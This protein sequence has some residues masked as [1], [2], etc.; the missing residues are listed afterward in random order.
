MSFTNP[1]AKSGP[2]KEQ[3]S[4][5]HA[6]KVDSTRENVKK[7]L[8]NALEKSKDN[9]IPNLV[10]T[11]EQIA[12]EIEQEVYEQNDNSAK[13]RGYRD[14]IRKLEM[15]IKGMRNNYIREILKKGELSVHDFCNL[16]EKNLNDENFFKKFQK[17]GGEG[18]APPSTQSLQNK[19]NNF[20]GKI[21]S[22][23]K[24]AKPHIMPKNIIPSIRPVIPKP[25]FNPPIQENNNEKKIENDNNIITQPLKEETEI[26]NEIKEVA[27]EKVEED[28]SNKKNKNIIKN[29]PPKLEKNEKTKLN[30][31]DNVKISNIDENEQNN[32]NIEIGGINIG[33]SEDNNLVSI[34]NQNEEVNTN[35][36]IDINNNIDYNI[37]N[38][39]NNNINI[40]EKSPEI[41]NNEEINNI[42]D[43]NMNINNN[44]DIKKEKDELNN[45]KTESQLKLEL[46][47]EKL[48]MAKSTKTVVKKPKKKGKKK[49]KEHLHDKNQTEEKKEI[50]SDKNISITPTKE[51]KEQKDE[52]I[53]MIKKMDENKNEIKIIEEKKETDKNIE[54][55]DIFKT[56]SNIEIKKP[57]ENTNEIKDL[58][59]RRKRKNVSKF[60]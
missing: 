15:R 59:N 3:T 4:S 37:D 44:M 52:N 54:K 47:Q 57:E 31:I 21:P 55:N 29:K 22:I 16:D 41:I 50:T 14:K 35:N 13:N 34:S 36:N 56:T 9:S 24:V 5:S 18:D 7:Q 6:P 30:E 38:N 45:S 27:N 25:I 58:N 33:M 19:K 28:I 60:K 39:I 17:E 32:N 46:L 53:F 42:Q 11:S 40:Q 23:S 48:K 26:K 51:E 8:I 43:N 49:K 10:K 20:S 12:I 2:K 1:F